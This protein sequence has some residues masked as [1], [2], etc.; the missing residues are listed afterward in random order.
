MCKNN[1]VTIALLFCVACVGFANAQNIRHSKNEFSIGLAGGISSL[2]YK[3]PEGKTRVLPGASLSFNETFFVGRNVGIRLG[4]GLHFYEASADMSGYYSET[5]TIDEQNEELIFRYRLNKYRERQS[6]LAV[7]IPLMLHFRTNDI[8]YSG[9]GFYTAFGLQL[10]IPFYMGY[11]VSA[12]NIKTTGY[13]PEHNVEIEQPAF[14][15]IGT[16]DKAAYKGRYGRPE[17][18]LNACLEFGWKFTLMERMFLYVGIYGEYGLLKRKTIGR[19]ET[20]PFI[21]H[22]KNEYGEHISMEYTPV[23]RVFNPAVNSF[24]TGIR[25]AFAIAGKNTYKKKTGAVPCPKSFER[26]RKKSIFD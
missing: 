25:I 11:N 1:R 13:Y 4:A 26:P 22:N 23:L 7:N 5:S 12:T 16:F 6:M 10:S 2:L 17:V 14:V 19:N 3:I 9:S 8:G 15:G 24:S 18:N 21:I 20:E